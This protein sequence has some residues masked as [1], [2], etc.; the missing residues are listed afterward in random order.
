M[1]NSIFETYIAT[2]YHF[3]NT[4]TQ[5]EGHTAERTLYDGMSFEVLRQGTADSNGR[6]VS[7]DVA[8]GRFNYGYGF[9]FNSYTTYN[10]SGNWIFDMFFGG[11]WGFGAG[12]HGS[13]NGQEADPEYYDIEN[14]YP[15]YGNG[16]AVATY[17]E[18]LVYSPH[19]TFWNNWGGFYSG[20]FGTRESYYSTYSETNYFATDLLGSV[21]VTTNAR[22]EV[23]G[24]T[25]Y[26]VFGSLY[27]SNGTLAESSLMF[28]YTGKTWNGITELSNYGFRDYS[29][30]IARFTTVDPIRDGN[31]WYAYV[32][33]DPAN[34]VDLWGLTASDKT[35]NSNLS[36]V[37][38]SLDPD[39]FNC[40]YPV[41][42][43]EYGNTTIRTLSDG[44]Y[45][46]NS[47]VSQAL[48]VITLTSEKNTSG[49]IIG[50]ATIY[51]QNTYIDTGISSGV[52]VPIVSGS[53]SSS[54]IPKG[55]YPSVNQSS[56]SNSSNPV[57]SNGSHGEWYY[58]LDSAGNAFHEG[59]INTNQ[60][61]A[62]TEGCAAITCTTAEYNEYVSNG[63]YDDNWQPTG[64]TPTQKNY[65]SAMEA[66][67]NAPATFIV[68]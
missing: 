13:N 4:L 26:D 50:S 8:K 67:G 55:I 57:L 2:N 5:T 19:E 64:K 15:L 59:N 38:F 49:A 41:A 34:C 62:Y 51:S 24:K 53:N 17:E 1:N 39:Q 60:S 22:G 14:L 11:M 43:Q 66:L 25:S 32:H 10:S 12:A 45:A 47:D 40:V 7:T 68:K 58:V 35:T 63:G 18:D 30:Q 29:P 27:G 31:N 46:M 65:D 20:L 9:P 61:T 6:F 23:S 54:P 37:S 44:N 16:E 33:N 42:T 28:A 52:T 56:T 3:S 48:V 21:K 36:P